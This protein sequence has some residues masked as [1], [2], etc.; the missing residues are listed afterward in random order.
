MAELTEEQIKEVIEAA[1]LIT[2]ALDESMR[3][4]DELNLAATTSDEDLKFEQVKPGREL[5]LVHLSGYD[6]TS[7]PT[8]IKVGY[9]NGHRY[10]WLTTQP[11]PLIS[12]TVAY[13]GRLRL[14]EG[15]FP[16]VRFV[17][18]TDG[19]DI[20]AALNGYWIKT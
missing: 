6:D 3:A 9:W 7:S 17:G 18:C 11:A 10:N 1:K 5:M 14:R 4:D 15:M 19:D 16:V 2:R 12:E 20:Y 13:N 8:R